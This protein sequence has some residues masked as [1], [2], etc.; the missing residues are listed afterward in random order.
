MN[1]IDPM[2]VLYVHHM[3]RALGF[4]PKVLGF[5]VIAESPGWSMLS[6]SGFQIGLHGI[7]P[8]VSEGTAAHA[9]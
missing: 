8:G 1:A 3:S 2:I 5:D 9:G 6:R 7:Y 4:Y